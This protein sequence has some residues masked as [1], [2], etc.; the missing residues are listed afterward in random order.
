MVRSLLGAREQ[1]GFRRDR[2]IFLAQKNFRS[3]DRASAIQSVLLPFVIL[4]KL[5]ELRL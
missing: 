2:T 3:F 5:R 4:E 1:R